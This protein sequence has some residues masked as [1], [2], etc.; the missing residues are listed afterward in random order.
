M[1]G[2]DLTFILASDTPGPS[3]VRAAGYLA[4]GPAVGPLVVASFKSKG[5]HRGGDHDRDALSRLV[6]LNAGR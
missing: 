6:D 5:S 3:G 2:A 4:R 1:N